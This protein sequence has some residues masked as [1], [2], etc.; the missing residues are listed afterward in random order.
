MPPDYQ[1]HAFRYI[2][3]YQKIRFDDAP[4]PIYGFT[5]RTRQLFPCKD[6][7]SQECMDL[8]AKGEV[9]ECQQ[10]RFRC[11]YFYIKSNLISYHY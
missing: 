11:D 7:F 1:F 4:G 10:D 2:R 9:V 8:E 6:K 3:P 5:V